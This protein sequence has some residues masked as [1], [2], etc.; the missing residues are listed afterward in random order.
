MDEDGFVFVDFE[1]EGV[2]SVTDIVVSESAQQDGPVPSVEVSRARTAVWAAAS[3]TR[4]DPDDRSRDGAGRGCRCCPQG[5]TGETNFVVFLLL[6]VVVAAVVA[7]VSVSYVLHTQK[8]NGALERQTQQEEVR[9]VQA[10]GGL[11]DGEL[12]RLLWH[13][14]SSKRA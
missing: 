14:G 11:S 2:D 6:V 5:I 12:T 4:F 13:Q 3:N 9:V 1:K 7:G 10:T 8:R